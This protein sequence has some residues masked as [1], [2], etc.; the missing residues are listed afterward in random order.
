MNKANIRLSNF[1]CMNT[2]PSTVYSV[3]YTKI[4]RITVPSAG[5]TATQLWRRRRPRGRAQQG[6]LQLCYKKTPKQLMRWAFQLQFDEGPKRPLPCVSTPQVCHVR[7]SGLPRRPLKRLSR[8][9]ICCEVAE[10]PARSQSQTLSNVQALFL[11]RI[12][13]IQLELK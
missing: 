6:H 3:H 11:C 9:L 4:R 12:G 2:V 5:T 1:V 13:I 10:T 8:R 7:W